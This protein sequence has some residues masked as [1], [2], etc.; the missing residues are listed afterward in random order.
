MAAY[1]PPVHL[2]QLTAGGHFPN[3]YP[4]GPYDCAVCAGEMALDAYTG[5]AAR[6]TATGFRALQA[7]QDGNSLGRPQRKP[8]AVGAGISLADI[9]AA[10]AATGRRFRHGTTT[11]GAIAARLHAGQGVVVPGVYLALGTHRASG[12]AGP[13]MLYLQRFVSPG[14]IAGDD[15]LAASSRAYPEAVLQRFWASGGA[16]AGWGEPGAASPGDWQPP[17]PASLGAFSDLVSF[18]VGHV[19]TA[20]DVDLIMATLDRAH[21]WTVPGSNP[22]TEAQAANVTRDLLRRYIGRAWN[23]ALQDEMSGAA[24]SAANAANPANGIGA[25]I[26]GLPDAIGTVLRST[27]LFLGLIALVLVG[28][29]LVVRGGAEGAPA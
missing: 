17:V 9:A 10:W 1:P 18:P 21:Y 8:A 6:M 24:L 26:A 2:A 5:G 13:H 4:S 14:M 3:G 7:D 20:A 27:G 11:W 22:L 15:P 16:Q 28:L 29:Y 23:K 19:L 25:A 12:F